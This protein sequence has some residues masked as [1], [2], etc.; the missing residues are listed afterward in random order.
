M[1]IRSDSCWAMLTK[2][3]AGTR[4]RT[5]DVRGLSCS[6]HLKEIIHRCLGERRKRYENANEL[7]EAL[8]TH[9]RR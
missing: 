5:S 3:D 7:I 8:R 9:R 4:I 1:C 6:D 2:G